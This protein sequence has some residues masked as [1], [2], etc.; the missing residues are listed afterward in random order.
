MKSKTNIVGNKVN[1]LLV[2]HFILIPLWITCIVLNLDTSK[3]AA[4]AYSFAFIAYVC[5][6]VLFFIPIKYIIY[7][8]IGACFLNIPISSFYTSSTNI[9]IILSAVIILARLAFTA[10]NGISFELIKRNSGTM[11]LVFIILSY[12]FSLF[13]VRKGWSDHLYLYSSVLCAS[14]MILMIVGSIREKADIVFINKIL[15][16]LLIANLFF[17]LLFILFPQIDAMRARLF[18]LYA[19]GGEGASRLQGLSFRGEAYGEYLMMCALWL[20]IMLSTAQ[21]KRWKWTLWL[22]T[23]VVIVALTLTR[24]R[25]AFAV[26]LMGIFLFLITSKSIGFHKK[27]CVLG[28]IVLV[29]GATL[30]VLTTFTDRITILDRLS[31]F[32]EEG[33]R[34]GYI[35]MTRY[36]TWVPSFHFAKSNSFMGVGPSIR[37]YLASTEDV[38]ADGFR[39]NVVVWPH[40]VTL[41]ILCTVGIYGLMSYLFLLHRTLRLR[42]V[43]QKLESDLR[44]YYSSYLFCFLMFLIEAQKYDGV[45]RQSGSSLYLISIVIG[46]LFTC[47]NMERAD[48]AEAGG[49]RSENLVCNPS[50]KTLRKIS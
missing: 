6:I 41:L 14:V 26:F 20:V 40:N 39:G 30:Y 48:A 19:L 31:V 43:L 1:F 49:L 32:L 22:I 38:I 34:V 13:F 8:L 5:G 3:F 25:G 42:K 9:F 24:L 37:P 33:Q 44:C 35:P 11:P 36:R 7:F 23:V 45:L 27:L 29:L 17:S 46:L 10:R 21:F 15:F 2:L 12:A 4:K 28:A 16:G 18:S 50:W 47:E